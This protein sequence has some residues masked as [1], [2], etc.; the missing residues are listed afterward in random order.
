MP[1]LYDLFCKSKYWKRDSKKDGEKKGY[2]D[3]KA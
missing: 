2:K 1:N 3:K